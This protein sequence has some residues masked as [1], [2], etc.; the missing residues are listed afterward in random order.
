MIN[1]DRNHPVAHV[2]MAM[3]SGRNISFFQY[4]NACWD[5]DHIEKTPEQW[6]AEYSNYLATP[7]SNKE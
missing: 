2:D 1:D 4:K 3:D 6:L 5:R 7:S